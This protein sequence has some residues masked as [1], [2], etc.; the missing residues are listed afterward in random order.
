MWKSYVISVL[1]GLLIV[2]IGL[3]VALTR[4]VATTQSDTDRLRSRLAAVAATATAFTPA[5]APTRIG[6]PTLTVRGVDRALL[7][8]IEND[9][10]ALRGLKPTGDVPLQFLDQAALQRYFVDRFNRDYLPSDRESDQ[11]LLTTLGLIGPNENVAQ[12][13]L[14]ILQE[15]VI[16][17]YS[18]DDKVMYM[19]NGDQFGP[20]EKDTFA[21]EFTHAL[22][23]Q[24]Y[25]LTKL[26]PKHPANDDQALAI[27]AL[28]EG[29]AVLMQRLWA[30]EKMTQS[31]IDQLGQGGAASKL[32]SAPLFMR[33]QL[34][35]PYVDGFNFVRQIY[36][37]RGGYAG[38]DQI[39]HDPPQSTAQ[40]L[41]P[42][43]YWAHVTPQPVS[44][45]DLARGSLG[46]GWRE[47]NSNVMGELDLRLI[48]TQLTNRPRAVRAAGGW[49]GD[50]WQL[51]EKDGRQALVI[52]TVWDSEAEART[53]FDTVGL[54][55]RNR[56][57]TAQVEES[58]ATRQALTS[59]D[60][61][62][63]VVRD[64]V[65]VLVV[66]SFDRPSAEA[67]VSSVLS[68]LS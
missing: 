4:Q 1:I 15:Q 46:T 52:K 66:I 41:H 31:E 51:L 34:L 10:V 65:N 58:S 49:A 33:E 55:F 43:K 19:V 63:D 25:D 35:F 18:A 50:R 20:D 53:F 26:V 23:D 48:L 13:L 17:I 62:T 56:F 68:S 42:D 45:P 32:F 9:V 28:T 39:F 59:A 37:T 8:Q 38:V 54:G 7:Q 22:Q 30:Q 27:Q 44:L 11:K 21:H 2:S 3:N 47:I 6:V 67:I 57:A 16:G 14:D 5:L 64:G 36:Q 24:H 61:A 29:D 40:I 60:A 12:T